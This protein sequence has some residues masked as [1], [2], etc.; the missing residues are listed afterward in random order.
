MTTTTTQ[1]REFD[2]NLNTFRA[3]M[4]DIDNK[5]DGDAVECHFLLSTGKVTGTWEWMG[6]DND[7][8]DPANVAIVVAGKDEPPTYIPVDSIIAVK[9]AE[10]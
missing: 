10:R 2:M 3:I 4:R 9:V 8:S 6:P 1:P 5:T 7:L